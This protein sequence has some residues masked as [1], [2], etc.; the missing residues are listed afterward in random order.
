MSIVGLVTLQEP[1]LETRRAMTAKLVRA[2]G[3][4]SARAAAP[5]GAAYAQR[6]AKYAAVLALMAVDQEDRNRAASLRALREFVLTRRWV[7]AGFK[8]GW[9]AACGLWVLNWG[10]CCSPNV[11]DDCCGV[12]LSLPA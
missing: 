9:L 1:L 6:A 8:L 3:W 5:G 4:L 12:S 10:S 2:V 11:V 7:V